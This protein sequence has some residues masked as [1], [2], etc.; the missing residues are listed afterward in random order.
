MNRPSVVDTQSIPIES[1]SSYPT[2]GRIFFEI[3]VVLAAT[4]AIALAVSAVLE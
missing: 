3:G 4:L 2:A 1:T